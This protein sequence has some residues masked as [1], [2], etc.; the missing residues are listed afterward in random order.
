MTTQERIAEAVAAI[1]NG[2][3]EWQPEGDQLA[4]QEQD[5]AAYEDHMTRMI[6]PHVEAVVTG[7]LTDVRGVLNHLD[8]LARQWGDEAQ[9]RR[10]RDRLREIVK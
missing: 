5:D 4:Q 10:C 3:P 6:R 8:E 1:I 2:L 9:Y 7:L